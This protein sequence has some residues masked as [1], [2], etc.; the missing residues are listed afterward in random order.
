MKENTNLFVLL[1]KRLT[2]SYSLVNNEL[3][4]HAKDVKNTR[5]QWDKS[6]NQACFDMSSWLHQSYLIGSSHAPNCS[7][8]N[9]TPPTSP[10]RRPSKSGGNGKKHTCT[11]YSSIMTLIQ[12]PILSLRGSKKNQNCEHFLCFFIL[13]A[14]KAGKFITVQTKGP[15]ILLCQI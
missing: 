9:S 12:L 14:L 4:V 11:F 7:F 10:L 1:Y 5:E 13:N 8:P 6:L 3:K 15:N 2:I